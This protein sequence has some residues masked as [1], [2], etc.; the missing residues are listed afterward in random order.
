[1]TSNLDRYR[2]DLEALLKEGERLSAHMR[3][4]PLIAEL[5][6]RGKPNAELEALH[7]KFDFSS[8]YQRWYSASKALIRQLL[9]DRL[10]DFVRHYE[11]PRQ[12]KTLSAESYR[13]EDFLQGLEA[14]MNG[15]KV[16]DRSAGIPHFDQQLAMLKAVRGRFESSLF[17]I[18]QLVQADLF[19]SELEAAK[20]LAKKGFLRAAGA[21]V[22]VVIE[23]HLAQ[24]CENH[25]VPIAKKAPTIADFN[26]ALKAADTIDIPQWRGIQYLADLRNLCD[27]NK[28]QEPTQQQVAELV[29]G[30]NKLTKTLF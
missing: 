7:D 6:R 3:Q 5:K 1:M 10:D 20:E 18:K 22:G 11:K 9:P 2:S 23:K 4:I 16:L 28:A 12:R 17:D 21:M 14:T 29:D 25:K 30:V 15:E 27:H 24:V 13:L 8:A 26:E 19:D